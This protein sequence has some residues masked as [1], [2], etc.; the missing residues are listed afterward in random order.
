MLWMHPFY[1]EGALPFPIYPITNHESALPNGKSES[2][3]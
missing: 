2:P 3:E 1:Q